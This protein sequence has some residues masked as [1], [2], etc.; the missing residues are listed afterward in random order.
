MVYIFLTGLGFILLAIAI[1]HALQEHVFNSKSIL[2]PKNIYLTSG[3]QLFILFTIFI[4]ISS[5]IYP[6]W[7]L[8]QLAW[9]LG[10]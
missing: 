7:L 4:S 8:N 3:E 10:Q 6:D 1:M 2:L 5:G 9:I